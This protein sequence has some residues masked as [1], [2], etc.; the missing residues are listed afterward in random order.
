MNNAGL[1][2]AARGLREALLR[3][4]PTRLSRDADDMLI[5]TTEV[6]WWAMALDDRLTRDSPE[7]VAE[8]AEEADLADIAAGLRHARNRLGHQLADAIWVDDRGAVFP[9][10]FP[11]VFHELHWVS[12]EDIDRGADRPGKEA[13]DA[14]ERA[15]ADRLVRRTVPKLT[16]WLLHRPELAD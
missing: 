3:W 9:V 15:L 11:L 14:Y 12:R 16:G 4:E 7:Y 6:L 8:L 13:G 1:G 10:T 2:R 5:A